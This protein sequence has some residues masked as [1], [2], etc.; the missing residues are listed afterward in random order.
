MKSNKEIGKQMRRAMDLVPITHPKVK[1]KQ[2]IIE[3]LQPR[4]AAKEISHQSSTFQP[5]RSRFKRTVPG[6]Q[7]IKVNKKT[8]GN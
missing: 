1:S 4:V 3:K 7:I 5:V 8:N 6:Y 2:K